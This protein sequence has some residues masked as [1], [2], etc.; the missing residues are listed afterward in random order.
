MT[1]NN[2]VNTEAVPQEPQAP[3][4]FAPV[5]VE[6]NDD[7]LPVP[8]SA[9]V[10]LTA[11]FEDV[12]SVFYSS[13]VPDGSRETAI[14]IYNAMNTTNGKVADLREP[15]IVTD[16]IAHTIKLLDEETG[17]LTDTTR[18]VLITEDGKGYD[19]VAG[20]VVSSIQKIVGIVGRAPWQPGIKMMPREV[21]TR[22]GFKTLTIELM[23]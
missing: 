13:I 21:R 11:M 9:P 4:G 19:C 2:H 17:E 15:I 7:F 14:K 3:T 6:T 20:G 22:K 10:D 8:Q 18:C 5:P 1:K 23:A 12:S 16:I